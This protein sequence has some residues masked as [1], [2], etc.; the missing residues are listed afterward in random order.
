[1]KGINLM[2]LAV[3]VLVLAVV[4][5]ALAVVWSKHENRRAFTELQNLYSERDAMQTEW[6][7]LQLEQ[8]VWATHGR[9]ETLARERLQMEPPAANAVVIIKQ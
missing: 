5:S 2:V 4:S 6:G 9:I 7:Q 8:G 1:M 3:V